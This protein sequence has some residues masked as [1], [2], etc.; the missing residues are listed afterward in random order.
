VF[1]NGHLDSSIEFWDCSSDEKW[2]LYIVVDKKTKKF[3]LIPLYPSKTSWD[4]NKKEECD[5]IIKE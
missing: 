5:N 1:F 3:N 4:F 2:H